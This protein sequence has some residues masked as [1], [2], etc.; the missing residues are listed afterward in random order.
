[1]RSI[2]KIIPWFFWGLGSCFFS[3]QF[4]LRL[5]PGLIMN[6]VMTKFHVDAA[7]YGLLS[8]M[9]YFGYAGA[10]LPVAFLLDRFGPRKV[11]SLSAFLCAFGVFVFAYSDQWAFILGARFIIGVG[12][13]A[14]F[15]G[16]S[17]VI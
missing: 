12:S 5:L 9:Y 13:A 2:H 11:I 1:M 3:F 6:Q 17:K 8:S 10:Q 16:A 15:L 7:A 4:I 14:G